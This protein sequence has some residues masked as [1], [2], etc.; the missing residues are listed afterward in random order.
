MTVESENHTLTEEEVIIQ[1]NEQLLSIGAS[2]AEQ[3]FGLA[4]WLGTLPILALV[5]ILLA[6]KV[7]NIILAFFLVIIF[8][9]VFVAATSILASQARQHAIQRA[10]QEK[11]IPQIQNY[12]ISR[13]FDFEGFAA[14]ARDILP[15]EAPLLKAIEKM[16]QTLESEKPD[17]QQE[18]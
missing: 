7:I 12:A 10:I 9:L 8:F 11:T 4:I 6:F 14:K 17:E 2:S 16:T 5:A 3:S 1:L 13:P 15:T 18:T